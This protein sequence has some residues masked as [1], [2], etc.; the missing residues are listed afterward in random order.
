VPRC[1][2]PKGGQYCES[3][4]SVR[5]VQSIHAAQCAGVGRA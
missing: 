4:P 1:C 5:M 3:H 2:A